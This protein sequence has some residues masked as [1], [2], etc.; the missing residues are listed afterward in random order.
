MNSKPRV[1]LG[2]LQDE[3]VLLRLGSDVAVIGRNPSKPYGMAD[4]KDRHVAMD[5]DMRIESAFY[6]IKR[7]ATTKYVKK[8]KT[9]VRFLV[10]YAR[11]QPVP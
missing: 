5:N 8:L 9:E 2:G 3:S 11:W 6:Y 10:R 1:R 4:G 7:E